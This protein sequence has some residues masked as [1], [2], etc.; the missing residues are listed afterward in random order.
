MDIQ[1]LRSY[2]KPKTIFSLSELLTLQQQTG[3]DVNGNTTGFA[4]TAD[5][6]Y[7]LDYDTTI[8]KEGTGSIKIVND[9]N[10]ANA[11]TTWINS[12][13]SIPVIPA[14]PGSNYTL[15]INVISSNPSAYGW[16]K[17]AWF[18]S[19]NGLISVSAESGANTLSSWTERTYTATAPAN[20][21]KA[22]P[23]YR[24]SASAQNDSVHLDKMSFKKS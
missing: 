11:I 16:L 24:F 4:V 23:V 17:I 18:N 1:L 2:F 15:V 21:V 5:H 6:S 10:G 12:S 7:T 20:T 19:S 14:V 9:Y 13:S 8:Q 22:I 3:G